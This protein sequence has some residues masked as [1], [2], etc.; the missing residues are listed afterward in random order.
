MKERYMVVG[1]CPFTIA[2]ITTFTGL[3]IVGNADS[4]EK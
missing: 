3:S 4:H 1:G 2:G